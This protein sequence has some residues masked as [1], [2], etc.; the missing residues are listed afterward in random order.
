M[1]RSWRAADLKS[2]PMN[3]RGRQ[4]G[5]RTSIR[6]SRRAAAIDPGKIENSGI[7]LKNTFCHMPGVGE[8]LE[9]NLWGSGILSWDCLGGEPQPVKHV[10]LKSLLAESVSELSKGNPRYFADL[11][12]A[13][14]HW[15][16]FTEFRD[17]TAYLDIETNGL[18]GPGACITTISLYD[19]KSI[20]CYVKGKNLDDFKADIK[21]YNVL[22]TF[23]GRCFDIPFIESYLGIHIDHAHI[24]L[25]FVLKDLGF[26]GGLKNCEKKLGL[27]RGD[28]DGVDGYFAVLLWKEF[29][30]NKNQKALETLLA[31]NILDVINLEPLMVVAYNLKLAGT[32]FQKSRRLPMPLSPEPPFKADART[33]KKIF[34]AHSYRYA[35]H[36]D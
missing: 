9:R 12:P 23:N 34:R 19:G 28:L 32:P 14:E 22:V 17:S 5:H 36:P 7:M 10:H 15:R 26:A 11:L 18:G 4:P 1:S 33:I 13:R 31:Y 8:R 25:R 2:K 16:L 30:R 35:T 6:M 20:Y 21:K 27:E 29:K 24:D 3:R